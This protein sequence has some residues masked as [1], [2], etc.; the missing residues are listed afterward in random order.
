[1]FRLSI[2]LLLIIALLLVGCAGQGVVVVTATPDDVPQPTMTDDQRCFGFDP[3]IDEIVSANYCLDDGWT[4]A[5]RSIIQAVPD[6]FFLIN[7]LE[8]VDGYADDYTDRARI[9]CDE[10]SCQFQVN[11]G[12]G[13]I[14]GAWGYGQVVDVEQGCYLIKV[15]GHSWV[16][17]PKISNVMNYSLTAYVDDEPVGE[18]VYDT[19]GTFEAIF[20]IEIVHRR[21]IT[22]SVLIGV[23]WATP[24]HNSYI[25]L[26]GLGLIAVPD[27]YC[28]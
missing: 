3:D 9:E 25:D 27:D 24:G 16:N 17:D 7:V 12:V 20:P 18:G 4:V 14:D 28:K 1:M 10:Y 21:E 2:L 22:Y 6:S 8:N 15:S 23:G 5:N 26:I 13:G 11:N 19:Q